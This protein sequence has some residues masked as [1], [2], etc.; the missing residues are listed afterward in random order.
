LEA[1]GYGWIATATSDK[2]GAF[3][4]ENVS[5]D[6]AQQ[7]RVFAAASIETASTGWIT[8]AD[9]VTDQLVLQTVVR[10]TEFAAYGEMAGTV[11]SAAGAPVAGAK[12][13]L[14]RRE[15]LEKT[16]MTDQYGRFLATDLP[17]S[18]SPLRTMEPYTVRISKAGYLSTSQF[19]TG[20][21][22]ALE[23]H[24]ATNTRPTIQATLYAARTELRGRITG[25]RGEAVANAEVY[26]MSSPFS[27]V[28]E[29][30]KTDAMGWYAFKNVPV[31]PG[32]KY[33]LQG[34][35]AGYH[36]F[37]GLEVKPTLVERQTLPT[38]RLT[39]RNVLFT[40]LVL[41][42]DGQ[43]ATGA[44]VQAWGPAGTALGEAQADASGFYRLTA[45]VP[46]AGQGVT[47][48]A[49]LKGFTP[50]ALELADKVEPGAT[51]GRDLV[52]VPAT[53]RLSGRVLGA[54]DTPLGGAKVELLKEGYGV[55][56]TDATNLDGSYRF[57]D[58]SVAGSG[59]FWLRVR[60]AEG[61]FAGSLRH[62]T[63][64]VPLLQLPP[65]QEI[66][67]DLLVK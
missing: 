64:L 32:A 60:P 26:L 54:G 51:L 9:G 67:T 59:W 17:G 47:L 11:L 66:V 29:M 35:A 50:G 19:V 52:V 31:L 44:S 62:Q 55:V 33:V 2:D 58:V 5:A 37:A 25:N 63:E 8:L 21:T 27:Q 30:V 7:Y 28:T 1:K 15:R 48:T 13:E 65:G 49:G 46:T 36:T 22:E 18:K 6:P 10:G 16:V 38:L 40:G 56:A 23:V 43:P 42:P 3:R 41:G 45:A 4:F 20:G 34:K 53:A 14:L 39:A 24:V 61:L 12:V 57:E